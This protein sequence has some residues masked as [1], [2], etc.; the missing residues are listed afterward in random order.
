MFSLGQSVALDLRARYH[1]VIGELR[2]M[3]AWGFDKTTMPLQFIEVG[4]GL[5]FFVKKS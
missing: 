2:P 5:K 4:A 3:S 1:V